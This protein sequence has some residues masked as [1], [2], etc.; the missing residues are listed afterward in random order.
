MGGYR[1][2]AVHEPRDQLTIAD[3]EDGAREPSSR[4]WPNELLRDAAEQYFEKWG[5]L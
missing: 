1:L 3:E 4:D 5:A 2:V